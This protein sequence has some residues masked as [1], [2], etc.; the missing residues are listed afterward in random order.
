MSSVTGE[1]TLLNDSEID[2]HPTSSPMLVAIFRDEEGNIISGISNFY[3][4]DL[5]LDEAAPFEI[6]GIGG[7]VPDSYSSFEVYANPWY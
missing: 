5:V 4:S 7:G 3:D 2:G 6:S 1:I